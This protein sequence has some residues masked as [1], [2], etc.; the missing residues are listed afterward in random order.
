MASAPAATSSHAH[1]IYSS[2]RVRQDVNK[3]FFSIYRHRF[4][5]C[6]LLP[7]VVFAT[8]SNN[9]LAVIDGKRRYNRMSVTT[10][11]L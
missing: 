11:K 1:V 2:I 9:I 5:T 8:I 4:I 3:L 7:I 10:A 6:P